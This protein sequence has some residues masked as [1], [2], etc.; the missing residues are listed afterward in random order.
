MHHQMQCHLIADDAPPACRT[1]LSRSARGG[2]SITGAEGAEV[3]RQRGRIATR[4]LPQRLVT[5][6]HDGLG[7]VIRRHSVRWLPLLAEDLAVIVIGLLG[8]DE[9]TD[10]MLRFGIRIT[11][12]VAN[13]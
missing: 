2:P 12:A 3:V 13:P 11:Q 9:D 8:T 6:Q 1:C 5:Q 7:L 4:A 10:A